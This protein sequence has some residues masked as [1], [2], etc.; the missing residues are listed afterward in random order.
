MIY[1][2][3]VIAAHGQ[4]P[5]TR[6]RLPA[7][8][9]PA[10][11]QVNRQIR[12]EALPMFFRCNVFIL[13]V[14]HPDRNLDIDHLREEQGWKMFIR[15]LKMFAA[16]GHLRLIRRLTIECTDQAPKTRGNRERLFIA[17]EC[18]SFGPH[19]Q[20]F[21]QCA[22]RL[23]VSEDLLRSVRRLFEED[24]TGDDD[25][26]WGDVDD[27]DEALTTATDEYASGLWRLGYARNA[28]ILRHMPVGG[29]VEALHALFQGQVSPEWYILLTAN[30][31]D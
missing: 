15:G 11:T 4:D 31:H 30:R 18:C 17:I 7:F 16:L 28:H 27:I 6:V 14:P 9:Q 23:G 13:Q 26:D 5:S 19:S 21:Q 20:E 24:R 8:R 1:R 25:T 2:F 10:F 22:Q 3:A 29:L 12:Q